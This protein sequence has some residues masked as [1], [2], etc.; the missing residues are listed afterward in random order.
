MERLRIWRNFLSSDL[1]EMVIFS[2]TS[3]MLRGRELFLRMNFTAS[4]R[5]LSL[6][7]SMS[8]ERLV[9]TRIGFT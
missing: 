9:M 7:A 4:A 5:S 3:K 1:R 2:V 8:V 6:I